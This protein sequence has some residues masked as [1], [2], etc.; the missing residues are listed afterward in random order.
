MKIVL[1]TKTPGSGASTVPSPGPG[2][3]GNSLQRSLA[4]GND[5][6]Y[7]KSPSTQNSNL[8]TGFSLPGKNRSGGTGNIGNNQISALSDS[9]TQTSLQPTP[10]A[11]ESL[12]T[13]STG[14]TYSSGGSG[15]EGLMSNS[16]RGS[17]TSVSGTDQTQNISFNQGSL[18]NSD[19]TSALGTADPEDYFTRID[20]DQD[21]F[22]IVHQRYQLKAPLLL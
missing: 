11:T 15:S 12:S 19:S 14:G 9:T 13:D 16:S 6:P 7:G 18:G 22:K 8:P 3:Y 2:E 4:A 17:K 1:T 5:L 10:Q 20:L 21:L